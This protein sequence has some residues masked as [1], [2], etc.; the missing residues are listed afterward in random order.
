MCAL[1]LSGLCVCCAA[2]MSGR[3]PLFLVVAFSLS[4]AATAP[5]GT[6]SELLTGATTSCRWAD[7]TIDNGGAQRCCVASGVFL[8]TAGL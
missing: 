1:W 8:P 5:T 3:A 6:G 2:G 7:K 4:A